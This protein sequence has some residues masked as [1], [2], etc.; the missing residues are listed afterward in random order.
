[1][2]HDVYAKIHVG[3]LHNKIHK[4]VQNVLDKTVGAVVSAGWKGC[5][6]TIDSQ[7]V[8]LENSARELLDP[9]L[10]KKAEFL[11]KIKDAI[12]G[13]LSPIL[14]E[15][16][17]PVITPVMEK[18]QSPVFN[19]YE[20]GIRTFHE[21]MS[22]IIAGGMKPKAVSKFL[23]ETSYYWGPLRP[24]YKKIR[25][26][27]RSDAME[28]LSDILYEVRWWHIEDMFED[29][30]RKLTNRAVFTFCSELEN[31]RSDTGVVLKETLMK[32]SHDAQIAGVLDVVSI[33]EKI[34]MPPFR[35]KV[36]P[37]VKDIISPISELI[38]DAVK[39]FLDPDKLVEQIMNDSVKEI[40]H[41]LVAG[42]SRSTLAK[43]DDV[44]AKLG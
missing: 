30:L 39:T 42:S 1:V 10:E 13:T 22:E 41:N 28:I 4:E 7:K 40:I 15:I 38:P 29:R 12:V 9:V 34:I 33:F 17:K 25:D 27:T 32:F 6:A 3:K 35:Q 5:T 44:A 19:M 21:Q 14:E 26:L 2:M 37:A 8:T 36:I 31:G 43:L 18:I 24:A 11:V 20:V 23:K 16:S